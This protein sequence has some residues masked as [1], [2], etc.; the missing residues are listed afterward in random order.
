MEFYSQQVDS[1]KFDI[2]VIPVPVGNGLQLSLSHWTGE[3]VDLDL[4]VSTDGGATWTYGGGGKG[5]ISAEGGVTF[6]FTYKEHPTHIRGSFRSDGSVT[7]TV[8]VA[9]G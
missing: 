5:V 2:P 8:K 3:P 6:H 7:A 4:D 1:D 9:V